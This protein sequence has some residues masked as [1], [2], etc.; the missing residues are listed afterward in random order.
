MS[1]YVEDADTREKQLVEALRATMEL[2][3]RLVDDGSI[4]HDLD[5]NFNEVCGEDRDD[6]NCEVP[7]LFNRAYA[8]A[9]KAIRDVNIANRE[10]ANGNPEAFG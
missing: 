2:L 8:M 7:T 1:T 3:Q 5:D 9:D 6:C 4:D 10:K